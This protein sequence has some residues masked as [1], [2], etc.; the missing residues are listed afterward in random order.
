[1]RVRESVLTSVLIPPLQSQ[2][3]QGGDESGGYAA[4]PHAQ[5]A[6]SLNN[7]GLPAIAS[8]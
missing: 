5:A 4:F 2:A 8:A 7:A 3:G 1:M 6:E